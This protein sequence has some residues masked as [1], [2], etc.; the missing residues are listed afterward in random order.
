MR[1][2]PMCV[3]CRQ[4]GKLTPANVVDH[5]LPHRGDA[6]L[7]WDRANLQ[8]VCKLCHDSAKKRKEAGGVAQG[9]DLRGMPL[10]HDHHWRKG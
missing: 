6:A 9:C 8:S 4:R 2:E 3:M 10:D 7:F 1:D 5:I